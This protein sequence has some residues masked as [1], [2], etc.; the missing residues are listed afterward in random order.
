MKKH[1]TYLLFVL[2]ALTLITGCSKAQSKADSFNS[3]FSQLDKNNVA[4]KKAGDELANIA[5]SAASAQDLKGLDQK[6]SAEKTS[7]QKL[8]AEYKSISEPKE[9]TQYKGTATEILNKRLEHVVIITD[10]L[11]YINAND[12]KNP[13]LLDKLNKLMAIQKDINEKEQS[14]VDLLSKIAKDNNLSI[15]KGDKI[16]FEAI[17]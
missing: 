11:N 10:I 6:L 7:V 2:I 15:A 14:N 16:R 8:L 1:C 17:K 12:Y 3:Y 9:L 13:E 5:A 4:Q